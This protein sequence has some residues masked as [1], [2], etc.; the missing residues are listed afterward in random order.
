MQLPS[1]IHILKHGYGY[2]STDADGETTRTLVAPNKYMIL[3]GKLLEKLYTDNGTLIQE[4]I[5]TQEQL[6]ITDEELTNAKTRIQDLERLS[7]DGN[8][9]GASDSGTS[10]GQS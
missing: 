5:K 3:A 9:A 6:K 4:V 2:D 8:V 7:A 1:L 10:E